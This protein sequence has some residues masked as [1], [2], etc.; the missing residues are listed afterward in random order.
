MTEAIFQSGKQQRSEN[1][2]KF[3]CAEEFLKSKLLSKVTFHF[4]KLVLSENLQILSFREN[5]LKIIK[6]N[7]H[8]PRKEISS[9]LLLV[10]S[11]ELLNIQEMT[12]ISKI[13]ILFGFLMM[14]KF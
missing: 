2:D 14:K 9:F 4:I 11:E 10:V 7:I 5:Y 8:I 13:P 3:K 6:T 1:M 12:S